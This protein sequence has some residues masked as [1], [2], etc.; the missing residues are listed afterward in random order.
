MALIA[1]ELRRRFWWG[2]WLLWWLAVEWERLKDG[3]ISD[4]YDAGG[5]VDDDVDPYN[6]YSKEEDIDHADDGYNIHDDGDLFYK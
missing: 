4:E 1:F 5:D 3:Y 6:S 2:L